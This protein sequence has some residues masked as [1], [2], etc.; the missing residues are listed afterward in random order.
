MLQENKKL[1]SPFLKNAFFP[2]KNKGKEKNLTK[3]T[4]K[5]ERFDMAPRI[6]KTLENKLLLI[7]K[8]GDFRRPKITS[9]FFMP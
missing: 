6:F 4:F 8:L 5:K 3:L 7:G 9:L 1:H 2:Q